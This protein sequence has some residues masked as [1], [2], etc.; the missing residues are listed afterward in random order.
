[1]DYEIKSQ[2][3]AMPFRIPLSMVYA[4]SSGGIYHAG[5]CGG[6]QSDDIKY[7]DT[8]ASAFRNSLETFSGA[9]RKGA[10]IPAPNND[11]DR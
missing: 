6:S 4:G 3:Y 11:P 2:G 8:L 9:Y 5:C 7:C 1:M 10:Y